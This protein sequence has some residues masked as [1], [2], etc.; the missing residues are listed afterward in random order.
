MTNPQVLFWIFYCDDVRTIDDLL[1]SCECTTIVYMENPKGISV[2]KVLENMRENEFKASSYNIYRFTMNN[3]TT[4]PLP[5][6][7]MS[8]TNF[9]LKNSHIFY[10]D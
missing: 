8:E 1:D 10:Y 2:V 3:I 7:S 6:S 5:N 9:Y 4:I